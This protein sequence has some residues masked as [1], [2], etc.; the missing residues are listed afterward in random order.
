MLT[1]TDA[2]ILTMADG[3]EPVHG[4]LTVGEDGRIAGIGS[5]EPPVCAGEILSAAGRIVAPGFVS[6]HSHLHTS[7]LRGLAAG[8]ALYPWLRANT[9]L[10]LGAGAEDMYWLTLHGCLDFIGNGI[11][12]AYNFALSR[13]LSPYDPAAGRP[14]A[15]EIRPREFL[16]RQFDAAA[17]SGLRVLTSLRVEDEALG[18]DRAV[19]DFG[20]LAAAVQA[21]TPPAW[22]LGVSV[23]GGVQWS[24]SP[25][26]AG[27]EARLMARYG[28]TNQAH[29]VETAEHL[30]AQQAKF[31]WYERAGALGPGMLFGH[32]VH[33]T[34]PMVD[35]VARTGSGVVW[36]PTANGRL[37]SGIADIVGYRARGIPVGMGL[38]DQ[39]CTDISD[40]F[41]NLRIGMY[42]QR[43][44]RLDA[45]ALLPR[46][47][48]RMHTLGAAEILGV[49][50][51]VGSLEVGKFADFLV[52]DPLRPDTGPIWDVYATYV[53]ACGLRN[54]A[55]VWIG[56]RQV[57]AEGHAR[58]PAAAAASREVHER[59]TQVARNRGLPPPAASSAGRVQAPGALR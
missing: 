53:M 20:D 46:E 48:L 47:V 41:Q 32:F 4:W 49:A 34:G 28:I 26:T 27:L 43:A 13:V 9:K 17:D 55:Q 54:L 42:S 44:A 18:P 25:A 36:Q 31:A 52:V 22:Y 35:A 56:G 37:G 29:F 1:V 11:T 10:Q 30:A 2:L 23:Y 15:P 21:A 45:S 14:A 12:S 24:D 40:P 50:D 57:S 8:Q 16:T 51:R 33:P 7:G 3:R 58:H 6:A 38:D 19:A 5:G 59:M 39:S